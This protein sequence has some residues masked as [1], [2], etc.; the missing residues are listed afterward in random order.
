[1]GLKRFQIQKNL[2]INAMKIVFIFICFVFFKV[3][4][5]AQETETLPY[6]KLPEYSETFTAGTVAAR[7]VDGLGFRYYWASAHLNE[8]DLLYKQQEDS[9]TTGETIDHILDLSYVIVN[10][11]LQQANSK[12]DTSLMTFEDKRKQTLYN[13]QIAADILR[14]S[15]DIS[16]FYIISG[17]RKTPFWNAINGPISDAIWHCGQIASYRRASGNPINPNVN[18]FMGTV[19]D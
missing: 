16:Q 3:N 4:L 19:R 12:N 13:L 17:E 8:E 11:T 2:K 18:H 15:D 7:M 1:M 5:N 6:Y 9:R 10:A 14:V